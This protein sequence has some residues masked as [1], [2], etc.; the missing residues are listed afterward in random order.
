LSKDDINEVGDGAGETIV[1]S[2]KKEEIKKK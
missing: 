1:S 2:A